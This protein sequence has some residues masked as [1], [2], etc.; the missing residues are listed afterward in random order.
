[1]KRFAHVLILLAVLVPSMVNAQWTNEPAG[2]SVVVNCDFNGS[3]CNLLSV[4]NNV[5]ISSDPSAPISPNGVLDEVLAANAFTG[6]GQFVYSFQNGP[7]REV[8]MGTSWKTNSDF[9]GNANNVNKL[10]FIRGQNDANFL[11]WQGLQGYSVAR[12]VQWYMQSTQYD[13]CHIASYFSPGCSNPAD[14]PGTGWFNPNV[15]SGN[16]LP[17]SGYH[18]L[19][20]YMKSSTTGTSRDGILKWWIDGTLVGSFSNANLS[21]GGFIDFQYNHTWDGTAVYQC[22]P[23]VALGRD[24]SKSWH[25]T[26]DHLRL[27]VPNCPLGCS[28]APPGPPAPPPSPPPPP[29]SSGDYV[30]QSQ[31]SGTQGSGQW[32][33]RDTDGNLLTYN[34]SQLKWE[35]NQLHLAVWGTGFHHGFVT[36]YRGPVVRWTAH[37]NGTAHITGNAKMYEVGGGATFKIKHN[38]TEIYSQGMTDQSDHFY[39]ETES[40]ATGEYIDFILVKDVAGV[41]NNTMLNPTIAWTTAGSPTPTVSGFSPSSG[42]PGTVVTITGTNFIPSLTGQ[43]VTFS[44]IAAAVTAATATS[45]TAIVPPHALTGTVKVTTVNGTGTSGSNFTVPLSGVVETVSDVTASALSAT[46]ATVQFTALSDGAGAAAKHDVRFS[47]GVISWGSA[48][49]VVSGTCASPFT[50]GVTN[51]VVTCTI[52]GL[53]TGTQYDVQMVSYKGTPNVD[54]VYSNLSNIATVTPMGTITDGTEICRRE[55]GWLHPV[56]SRSCLAPIPPMPPMPAMQ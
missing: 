42:A 39:D 24:C 31:F 55:D 43:T 22:Y 28:P 26:W 12:T 48:S 23:G 47:A 54:A 9:Q 1:M 27:S 53:T 5:P 13:N 37:E 32:S 21:P 7:V 51:T 19:E 35:G 46:S 34:S 49:S 50:P 20:I 4:Y 14:G 2:S 29:P 25:H 36:P 10:I 15:G 40:M 52:T 6:G 56:S 3:L 11:S 45:I 16:V 33:Y 44:N 17:G 30:F 38:S 41:N 8:Y 18:L